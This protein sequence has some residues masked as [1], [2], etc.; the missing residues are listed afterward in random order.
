[1]AATN[2]SVCAYDYAFE[3]SALVKCT[4]EH[5]TAQHSPNVHRNAVSR[6]NSMVELK[7]EQNTLS[8]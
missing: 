8:V 1:M 6:S 3:R 7:C 4:I 5:S 2:R